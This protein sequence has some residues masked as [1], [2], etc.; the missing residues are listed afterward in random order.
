M[1]QDQ[2]HKWAADWVSMV[3]FP[4][5]VYVFRLIIATLLPIVNMA[6]YE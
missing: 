3:Q 6:Y 1:R 2:C 4:N 5:D